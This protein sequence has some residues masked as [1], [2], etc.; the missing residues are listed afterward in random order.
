MPLLALALAVCALVTWFVLGPNPERER[1]IA[2]EAVQGGKWD[3]AEA[4]LARLPGLTESDWL[5]RAEAARNRKQ[6]ERALTF[7]S[8][9]SES[10]P[11][12]AKAALVAGETEQGRFRAQAM[13][14]HLVR[15]LRLDPKLVAARRLLIYLYGTQGRRADVLAQFSALVEL[16]PG[17]V[18]LVRHWCLSRGEITDPS[19]V[20]TDLE[21]FVAA[22]PLD[23]WSRLALAEAC[24]RLSQFD[25]AE[26]L[27]EPLREA[28]PEATAGRAQLAFERGNTHAA[29]AML[30]DA[31]IDHAR[32]ARLR[33]RLALLRGDAR[34]AVHEFRLAEA[35]EPNHRDTLL[36]LSQALKLAGDQATAHSILERVTAQQAVRN[37][38]AQTEDE[39]YQTAENFAKLA[40]ACEAAGW[41]PEARAW[42]RLTVAADPLDRRAQQALFRLS[43]A[44]NTTPTASPKGV[45]AEPDRGHV[46]PAK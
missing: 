27:L 7:V 25:R 43:T 2:L 23:R 39:R 42:Y 14:T 26:K 46:P 6:F 15:A 13:E 31:P 1:K 45:A 16:N 12:G 32:L 30:R 24:R 34:G 5:L 29:E 35:A 44:A 8:H 3:Q 37:L 41:L 20:K 19:E 10:G 11:R 21:R 36:G 38:L 17:S 9:V 4:A 40:S 28:D 18:D 33:G 22:D